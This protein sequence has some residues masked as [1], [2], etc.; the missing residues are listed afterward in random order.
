MY[1]DSEVV[2]ED[3]SIAKAAAF[4]D[5]LFEWNGF[6]RN[7]F[8]SAEQNSEEF[9]TIMEYFSFYKEEAPEVFAAV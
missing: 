2:K 4:F 5:R 9:E 8:M 7:A 6:C 3:D 1:L